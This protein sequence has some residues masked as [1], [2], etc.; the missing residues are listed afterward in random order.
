MQDGSRAARLVTYA[1]LL[2]GS[3]V[4]SLPFLWMVGTSMKVDR[5]LFTGDLRLFPQSP[6]PP[7]KP[8]H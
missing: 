8:V 2:A 6:R 1:L 4:F 3:V 7:S 5:E